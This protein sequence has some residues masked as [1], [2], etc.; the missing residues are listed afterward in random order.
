MNHMTEFS[1]FWC[2]LE[3]IKGNLHLEADSVNLAALMSHENS[4]FGRELAK[5][6]GDG[7]VGDGNDKYALLHSQRLAGRGKMRWDDA[8]EMVMQIQ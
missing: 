7:G 1:L 5:F 8:S 6:G 4:K 2:R 3:A